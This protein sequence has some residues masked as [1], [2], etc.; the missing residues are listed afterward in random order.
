M[1]KEQTK[2]LYKKNQIEKQQ[3]NSKQKH[4]QNLPQQHVLHE[5]AL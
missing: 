2:K 1:T 5:L 4:E 3:E